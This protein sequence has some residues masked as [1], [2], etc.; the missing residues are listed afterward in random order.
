VQV[1]AGFNHTCAVKADGTLV[2]WGRND[3]GQA[4]IVNLAPPTLPV[5]LIDVPYTSTLSVADSL[6]LMPPYTFN[7]ISGTLPPGLSFD[8]VSRTLSG[9]PTTLGAFHFG[10]QARDA[11]NITGMRAYTMLIMKTIVYLPLVR[12]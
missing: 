4:P 6:G 2:C 11:N 7:I 12:K 9:T 8:T 5:G 10:V 3:Y 1:S